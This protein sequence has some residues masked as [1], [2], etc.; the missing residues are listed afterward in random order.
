MLWE[1]FTALIVAKD[2]VAEDELL[3]ID[4]WALAELDDVI[5]QVRQ[6]YE[7]YEFHMATRAIYSFC[8]VTL[9]ARYFDIIK[10]RLYTAA[11]RSLARRSAQTALHRIDVR[12]QM[13]AVVKPFRIPRHERA[14]FVDNPS[15]VPRPLPDGL[16]IWYR[17]C[18]FAGPMSEPRGFASIFRQQ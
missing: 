3:E 15:L 6:A 10:D 2:V 14:E 12:S 7:A 18:V 5:A 9:S 1:I 11:P 4:R 16:R 17:G 8:T 13:S